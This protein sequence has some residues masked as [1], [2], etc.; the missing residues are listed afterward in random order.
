MSVPVRIGAYRSGEAWID[1]HQ[2]RLVARLGFGDPF[3]TARVRFGGVTA[4]DQDQIGV[5][6]IA[7]VIGHGAAAKRR[8]KTCHRRTVSDTRLVIDPQNAQ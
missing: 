6:D 1:H 5:L 7:P 4:H 3:E 2:P 8:G